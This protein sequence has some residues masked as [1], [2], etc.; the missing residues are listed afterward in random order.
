LKRLIDRA[1]T[2]LTDRP[3]ERRNVVWILFG[4]LV[5]TATGVFADGSVVQTFYVKVGLTNARIGLIGSSSQATRFVSMSSFIGVADQVR[6]RVETVSNLTLL[7]ITLPLALAVV[8]LLGDRHLTPGVTFAVMFSVG[9]IG[10]LIGG[11]MAMMHSA[12]HA[13]V[14][15]NET[16]ARVMG[17][18]GVISGLAAIA[19]GFASARIL[20][21][22]GFPRGFSLCFG[23]AV[24]FYIG[25]ALIIRQ[26]KE[27]PELSATA[28]AASPSPI[29]ALRELWHL[30]QF[31]VLLAPFILR[32]M[33]DGVLFFVMATG[34]R[35][36]DL[37]IEY[38]GLAAMAQGAAAVLGSM[39]I[40][41]TVDR[42]GVGRVCFVAYIL[43]G[44]G[45]IGLV[46]TN[47]PTVF[48]I[49]Y[50]LL[51]YAGTVEGAAI[52]LGCYFVVPPQ[53]MASFSG[54]RLG[55]GAITAAVMVPAAGY[56]LDIFNPV[57]I[58]FV[59]AA[60]AVV[61]GAFYW[62]GFGQTYE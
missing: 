55:L 45:L 39:S 52:P 38:G 44:F 32:G 62:Y 1:L 18:T 29:A 37:P 16:R 59:G 12:M 25:A 42:F 24:V 33:V 10:G 4:A 27:M 34:L 41:L 23:A 14:V 21:T 50:F 36:L 28:T 57:P 51:T 13:R 5:S 53:K 56:L 48:L 43:V 40:A 9:V 26:L 11:V 31:R 6:R 22:M 17:L 35:R 58:F 54:A 30:R 2:R 3:Q 20:E 47:A 8:S 49:L 46:L 15:R 19:L 60:V 7:M 61:T